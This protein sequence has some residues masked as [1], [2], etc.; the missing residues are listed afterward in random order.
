MYATT[1]AATRLM[2]QNFDPTRIN[3]VVLLTDGKNEYPLDTDIDGLV[4]ELQSE[5]ESNAVRVFP[6]AYGAD[7]DLKTLQRI[8][9]ASRAAVYNSSDPASIDKVFA[10][11]ISNF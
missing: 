5:E 8:A 1:R 6:I 11:V 9:E 3:A 10:A 4:R 7:A 2:Q